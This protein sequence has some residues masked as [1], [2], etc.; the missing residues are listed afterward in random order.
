MRETIVARK[1]AIALA[2]A[3]K[4]DEYDQIIGE[5]RS[6][7][8]A[9]RETE[10]GEILTSPFVPKNK[11]IQLVKLICQKYQLHRKTCNFLS[12]VVGRNRSELIPLMIKTFQQIWWEKHNIIF[13]EVI[14]AVP[15]DKSFEQ[16]LKNVL[17][18]KH[19][20]KII[21][22]FKTDPS[23]L[24]GLILKR[25]FTVYDGSIRKQL[26]LIKNKISGEV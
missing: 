24:G 23:I 21:L 14:T 25:G 13:Y 15:I 18:N 1:Y 22:S 8:R 9:F 7:S 16:K 10:L 3:V 2:G 11:K 12:L 4:E 20:T 6:F 5:L 17:E 26:E 19:N